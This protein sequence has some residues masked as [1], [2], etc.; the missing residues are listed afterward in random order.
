[1]DLYQSRKL[2]VDAIKT[3][4]DIKAVLRAMQLGFAGDAT[5]GIEHLLG[6]TFKP[7]GFEAAHIE[8]HNSGGD[9]RSPQNGPHDGVPC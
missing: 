4:D 1:M 7:Y 5:K 2:N 9:Y 8:F 3:I 6:E